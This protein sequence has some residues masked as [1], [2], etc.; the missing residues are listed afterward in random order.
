MKKS[1]KKLAKYPKTSHRLEY[2]DA[3]TRL[4]WLS[5]LLDTY[6]VIDT[7]TFIELEDEELKRKAKV[8]YREG[9]SSCCLQPIV[10]ITQ[11]ELWGI[12]WFAKEKLESSVRQAVD[13]HV[14]DHSKTVQCPFLVDEDCA[15][16]PVRPIACRLLF[17]F[18]TPCKP[19]V[20]I[21]VAR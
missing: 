15:I 20:D 17:V 6:H 21:S 11:P 5:A 16:Y 19:D 7:G 12:L 1:T 3:E 14:M 8:A 10:P 4:H 9:C 13:K 18:G 2:P